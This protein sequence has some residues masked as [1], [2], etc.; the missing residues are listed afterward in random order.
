VI[1]VNIWRGFP[2][3]GIVP[4]D[5]GDSRRKL[6]EAAAVDGANVPTLSHDPAGLR[7]IVIIVVLL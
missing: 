4:G 1:F 6:Y 2:F 5:E 7:N 3:F